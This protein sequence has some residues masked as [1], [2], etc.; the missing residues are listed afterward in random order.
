MSE[1]KEATQTVLLERS[2]GTAMITLNR[3]DSLNAWT[4]DLGHELMDAV[5]SVAD[6]AEVRAIGITGAGRAFSSGADLKADRR[7]TDDGKPD[8]STGLR[9]IYNPII[10]AITATPKPFVASVNG[11]AAGIGCSL[12]LA[13]D[14]IVAAESSFF[15]LAFVRVGLVPDGGSLFHVASRVGLTR[16]IEMA[17]R[18]TRVPALQAAEW[19][20][21]NQAVP[22]DQLESTTQELLAELAAGPT[23]SY[24]NIKRLA[25]S[26]A[27]AGIAEQLDLE[28]QLQQIQGETA[29]YQEGVAAFKEKRPPRFTGS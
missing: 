13:C 25:R 15:L 22:D 1:T 24:G 28:A 29:D 11:A 2:G 21:I 12:A 16:A 23:V 9:E 17:M 6:D 18:G 14:L 5:K 27:V 7:T 8:M 3:P 4:P 10:E 26:G 19:G 20:L